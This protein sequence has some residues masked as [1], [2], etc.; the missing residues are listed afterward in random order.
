MQMQ[1]AALAR[2]HHLFE[3]HAL[4]HWLFGGWAVDFH[5]GSAT[6]VHDDIDIAIWLADRARVEALLASDGWQPVPDPEADGYARYERDAVHL[7][8]AFLARDERG[9]VYTPVRSGRGSWPDGT[10]GD[11][12]AELDGVRSRVVSLNAL[13]ADKS[14]VRDDPGVAAKDRADLATLAAI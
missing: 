13:R 2:L 8:L 6:R 1:L 10:F 5:A 7:E 4:D 9:C 3:R 14:E 12:V 11:D